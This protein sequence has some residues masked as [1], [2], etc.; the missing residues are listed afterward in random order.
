M[1]LYKFNF[2]DIFFI[3]KYIKYLLLKKKFDVFAENA[4]VQDFVISCIWNLFHEN[5]DVIY[6]AEKRVVKGDQDHDR[7]PVAV[8][9]SEDHDLVTEDPDPKIAEKVE[10]IKVEMDGLEGINY[11]IFQL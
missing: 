2:F 4:H 9:V 3:S 10:M 7:D 5:Y 8:I 11:V 6:I 1:E